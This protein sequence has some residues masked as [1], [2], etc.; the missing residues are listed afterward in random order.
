MCST[1]D[2]V[3]FVNNPAYWFIVLIN[4][5]KKWK[6]IVSGHVLEMFCAVMS[7]LIG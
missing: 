6:Y 5:L 3:D 2:T 4:V 7:A 1:I